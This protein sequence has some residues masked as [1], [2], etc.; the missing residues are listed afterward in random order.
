M[1]CDPSALNFRRRGDRELAKMA[2]EQNW[3]TTPRSRRAILHQLRQ[4]M[5]DMRGMTARD[6]AS[7]AS[8]FAA[9]KKRK[10]QPAAMARTKT[11]RRFK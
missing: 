4:I 11:R 9:W 6:R 10:P 1:R 8:L 3:P 5:R 2:A 7:V